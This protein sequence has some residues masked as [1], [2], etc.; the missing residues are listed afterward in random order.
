V[1]NP[2]K[3]VSAGFYLLLTSYFIAVVI[4]YLGA[5]NYLSFLTPFHYFNALVV[6]DQGISPLFLL[7]AAVLAALS[8]LFTHRIYKTRDLMV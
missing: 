2:R 8:F 3:A 7:L 6:V 4:E 5:L 1:Q